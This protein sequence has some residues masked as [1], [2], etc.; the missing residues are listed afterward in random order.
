MLEHGFVFGFEREV[1]NAA[2]SPRAP[3]HHRP[4]VVEHFDLPQIPG[5]AGIARAFRQ[6]GFQSRE[7]PFESAQVPSPAYY[8]A[9]HVA[10]GRN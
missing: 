3:E 1:R 2:A 8:K 9:T 6:P 7:A 4:R 5:R 10:G